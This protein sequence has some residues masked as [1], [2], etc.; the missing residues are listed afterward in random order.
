MDTL[1]HA[2]WGRG[3]FG[4]RGMPWLALFFGA[5]PDLASFGV[6]YYKYFSGSCPNLADRHL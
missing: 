6:L 5:M 1:S 2:L 4:H 3:L